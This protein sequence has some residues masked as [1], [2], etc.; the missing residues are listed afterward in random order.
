M[1]QRSKAASGG[2]RCEM[3]GVRPSHCGAY[4]SIL[5]CKLL[6]FSC[7]A[8]CTV[9]FTVASRIVTEESVNP[10]NTCGKTL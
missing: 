1:E 7:G 9:D 10:N 5:S 6:W 3:L 2:M 8:K 4:G